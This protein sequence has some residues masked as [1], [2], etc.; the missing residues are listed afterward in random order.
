M[1]R[2]HRGQLDVG[3]LQH[4]LHAVDLAAAF[5]HQGGAVARQIPQVAL[6]DRGDEAGLHQAMP[7]QFGQPPRIALVRL[8]PRHLLGMGRVDQEDREVA[9]QDV[10][11]GLPI[12]ARAFHGHMRDAGLDQPVGQGQ[13]VD[14]HRPKF[15]E[16]HDPVGLPPGGIWR[17]SARHH[18]LL[19]HIQPRA[20]GEDHVHGTPPRAKGLAGY[21]NVKSLRCVLYFPQEAGDNP[22]CLQV[23]GSNCCTGSRHHLEID[24]SA[25]PSGRILH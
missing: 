3:P 10:V 25:S 8:A 11:D 7:H 15:L 20:M 16:L 13:Q 9:F 17:D 18:C 24:L 22:W 21:P 12:L 5:L 4:S 6:R 23:S 19:M 2:R 14:G 1:F